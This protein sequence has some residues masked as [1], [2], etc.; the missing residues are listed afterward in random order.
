MT[1]PT[2]WRV[3][4]DVGGTFTDVVTVRDGTIHVTKTPSTPNVPDEGV[5]D[6]LEARRR[7]GVANRDTRQDAQDAQDESGLEYGDIDF[8]AHGT[9]VATNA[10]L[11]GEWADTALV[12]TGGFRDVLEIGRQARPD[13]YDFDVTKPEPIVPRDRRYEVTE[14]LDER[15]RVETPLEPESVNAVAD[16]LADTDVDSI[17]ISLLFSFENTDH[18]R[19]V[20]DRLED[21]GIDASFSLSSDVLPEI[22]EYERTLATALNAALKPVMDAY[23]GRL[24]SS[25]DDL[26]VPAP[27]RIM[28]SNGGLIDADQARNRPIN[29]LLS[30]PAA[31]VQGAA[32]VA[33][34]QGLE[35]VL[36]LDMGGTS[37]DVSMIRDGEPVV[38]TDVT[39]GDYP[40]GVS[41]VDVHTIGAGGGSIAWI[42]AGG[43]LR[44]GPRSAGAVPGPIC[45]GRGGEEPTVT[46]AHLLLGRLDPEAFL[47]DALEVDVDRVESIVA[48]RIADPLGMSIEE[49]AQG[50]LDVA[51][52][53]MERALRVVSVERGHDPREFVLVAFGGAGPLH[54]SALADG[55]DIPRVVVPRTAGVLS[56]LGL[57]LTDRIHDASTSMVR[58]LADVSSETLEATFE[59]LEREGYDRLAGD[60]TADD[61]TD[62]N[63]RIVLERAIDLRYV[64]QSFDLTIALPDEP[65]TQSVLEVATRRFHERH[66]QRYGHASPD[67]SIELVTVRLRARGLVDTPT[68]TASNRDGDPD[69][70]IRE[71]RPVGFDERTHD[72]RIYDRDRL[73]ADVAL[74]GPAIVE[75]AESTVVIRPGQHAT[76]DEYGSLLVEGER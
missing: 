4:V 59:R 12:T 14:R 62:E 61:G 71:E 7:H 40:V 33:G 18:E 50:I 51:N 60:G 63:G 11:E 53:N 8:F 24:A 72:T 42:D 58:R 13:I 36:T 20:R 25:I 17:A 75:G 19:R 21:V 74:E 31:G 64:G 30:G 16:A 27:L 55:L 54:A 2:G 41:M 9:T 22:R 37:C 15:G 6:G 23:I 68:L 28:Q 76:V 67:E 73:P 29:T 1:T 56:A 69:D 39:V 46:D 43:A 52:A 35:N 5:V 49:A 32:H 44:V 57:V 47:S 34:L 66:E 26:G 10:V 70:A 3:G 65:V 45:Y 48:E 38:S